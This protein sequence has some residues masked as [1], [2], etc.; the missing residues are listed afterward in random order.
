[1]GKFGWRKPEEHT[2]VILFDEALRNAVG[3]GC[4]CSLLDREI[5]ETFWESILLPG[6]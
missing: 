3:G 1:M 6:N 4:N 5:T 2:H